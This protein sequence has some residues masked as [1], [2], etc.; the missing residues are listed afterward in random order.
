[1]IRMG[2]DE[3]IF[4]WAPV[5]PLH[6]HRGGGSHNVV[7]RH[8]GAAQLAISHRGTPRAYLTSMRGR[9]GLEVAGSE[10]HAGASLKHAGARADVGEK[11][12][13]RRQ[14]SFVAQTARLVTLIGS[15]IG[16][17]L[18]CQLGGSGDV[19]PGEIRVSQ[20]RMVTLENGWKQWESANI[21]SAPAL[22]S[23][24]FGHGCKWRYLPYP[25]NASAAM[26]PRTEHSRS[27]PQL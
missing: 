5:F 2:R 19:R 17:R 4:I 16:S 18:G 6:P 22:S 7:E 3:Q 21:A 24:G 9:I 13:N 15:L 23:C 10:E 25:R 1:M 8:P 11:R 12:R 27:R 20:P 14:S 26:Y